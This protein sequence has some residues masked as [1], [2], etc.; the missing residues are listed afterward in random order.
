MKSG[1]NR[2]PEAIGHSQNAPSDRF[3]ASISN[4]PVLNEL[5]QTFPSIPIKNAIFRYCSMVGSLISISMWHGCRWFSNDAHACFCYSRFSSL[6]TR[7]STN[8]V[9]TSSQS[10]LDPVFGNYSTSHFGLCRVNSEIRRLE[11]TRRVKRTRTPPMGDQGR[12]NR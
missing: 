10:R 7:P 2:S 8:A 5:V 6:S 1:G 11:L 12:Q 3:S 4:F 9:T